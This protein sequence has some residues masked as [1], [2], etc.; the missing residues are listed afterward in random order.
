MKKLQKKSI[1]E[2]LKFPVQVQLLLLLLLLLLLRLLLPSG[3]PC[4]EKSIPNR[5][6]VG[7]EILLFHPIA[8]KLQKLKSVQGHVTLIDSSFAYLYFWELG[9]AG[10]RPLVHP[11]SNPVDPSWPCF[12]RWPLNALLQRSFNW[13]NRLPMMKSK[14][15]DIARNVQ[16]HV[17]YVRVPHLTCTLVCVCVCVL[18]CVL[19]RVGEPITHTQP[20]T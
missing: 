5:I 12:T 13:V 19:T 16:L 15:V 17:G 6:R 10:Q 18:V 7:R 9:A 11:R 4:A 20:S 1:V 8:K 2:K 14:W 3:W